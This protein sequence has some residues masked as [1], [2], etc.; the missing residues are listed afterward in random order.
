MIE[1]ILVANP[2]M[3]MQL[4][5]P[6]LMFN[7]DNRMQFVMR[8]MN[9]IDHSQKKGKMLLAHISSED[10][11]GS[12]SLKM[13]PTTT[14]APKGGL[15][16]K[17]SY[18]ISAAGQKLE[19]FSSLSSLKWN[20]QETSAFWAILF[21]RFKGWIQELGPSSASNPFNNGYG[22]LS[23]GDPGMDEQRYR[24]LQENNI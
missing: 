20:S 2:D 14:K 11:K 13:E 17:Q 22:F 23:R 6:H 15:Q 4:I 12:R 10:G 1:V 18:V 3:K 5:L 9:I 21:S 19:P 16:I 8:D 24:Y 7:H